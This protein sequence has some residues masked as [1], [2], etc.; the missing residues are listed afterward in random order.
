MQQ[1]AKLKA[2]AKMMVRMCP[3]APHLP[4]SAES[5]FSLRSSQKKNAFIIF[6]C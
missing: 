3:G 2:T 4:E 6:L 1:K 5:L